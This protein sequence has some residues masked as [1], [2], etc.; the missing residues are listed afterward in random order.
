MTLLIFGKTIHPGSS[1]YDVT[2]FTVICDVLKPTFL[3][4]MSLFSNA[5]AQLLHI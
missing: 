5:N 2:S 1:I 3:L 4:F